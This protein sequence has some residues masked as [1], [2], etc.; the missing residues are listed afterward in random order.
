MCIDK[1][2]L[3]GISMYSEN[4]TTSIIQVYMP[5]ISPK[6]EVQVAYE[7]M[8]KVIDELKVR[9]KISER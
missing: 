1:H 6:K 3:V 7:S 5:Y 9:G 2:F 8:K 4:S